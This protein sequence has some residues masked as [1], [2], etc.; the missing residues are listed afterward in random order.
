LK[1]LDSCADMGSLAFF[2][3]KQAWIA[4]GVAGIGLLNW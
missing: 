2:S 4:K 1:S 3:D